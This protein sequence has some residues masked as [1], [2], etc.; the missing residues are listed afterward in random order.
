MDHL[1][2]IVLVAKTHIFTNKNYKEVVNVNAKITNMK[3][4]N[5]ENARIVTF[6]AELVLGINLLIA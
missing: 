2:R 1:R 3:I 5:K 4:F 6:R